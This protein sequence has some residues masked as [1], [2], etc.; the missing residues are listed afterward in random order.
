MRWSVALQVSGLLRA[1]R[2]A[3]S[4]AYGKE[5]KERNVWDGGKERK[6]DSGVWCEM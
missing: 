3:T 6:H 4:N 5:E 2:S 1:C